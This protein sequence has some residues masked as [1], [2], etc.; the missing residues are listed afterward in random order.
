MAMILPARQAKFLE[1]RNRPARRYLGTI[2][3]GANG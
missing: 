1:Y 3:E 2:D